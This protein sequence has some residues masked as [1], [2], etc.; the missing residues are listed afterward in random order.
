MSD[1]EQKISP[2][3]GNGCDLT[4]YQWTQTLGELEVFVPFKDIGFPLKSKDLI[5]D[6]GRKNLKIGIKGRQMVID[7]ELSEEVKV[8]TANWMIEDGKAVV[9]TLDKVNG[10]HWWSRLLLTDPEIDTQKVQPENSKLS[11]LDGETR[12]MVEKMMYDQRQKELG[13]PTSE[14][15]K[16]QDILKKFME[17]HPEMDFSNAKFS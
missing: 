2:N 15:K 5:V 7:G 14:E 8:G 1:S 17:Q 12:S 11:D 6:V 16:K 4:N 10:M 9:L 13:L 3:V